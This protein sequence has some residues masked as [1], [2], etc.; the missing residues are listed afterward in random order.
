ME[1]FNLLVLF[2]APFTS[3]PETVPFRDEAKCEI[4]DSLGMS[5]VFLF[6]DMVLYPEHAAMEPTLTTMEGR[7]IA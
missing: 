1:L 6:F 4:T 3:F 7:A 5:T 2:I